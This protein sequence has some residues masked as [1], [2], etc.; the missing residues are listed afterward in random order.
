MKRV[1]SFI[2]VVLSAL[3]VSACG[4]RGDLERPPPIWG[5]APEQESAEES[6]N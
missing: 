6:E 5:D 4:M 3:V 1:T 2:L